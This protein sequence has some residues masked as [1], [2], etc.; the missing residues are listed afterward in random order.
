MK[1]D[2]EE[3][4]IKYKNPEPP[5]PPPEV[6]SVFNLMYSL[7]KLRLHIYKYTAPFSVGRACGFP[8]EDPRLRIVLALFSLLHTSLNRGHLPRDL[9][10]VDTTV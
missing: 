9:E 2:A 1:K 6:A 8:A 10:R 3:Y 7:A 4:S 5:L